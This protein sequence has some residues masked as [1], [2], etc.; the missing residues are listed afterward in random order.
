[1]GMMPK[2]KKKKKKKEK[3]VFQEILNNYR[4]IFL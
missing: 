4:Q 1:M 2:K 3:C